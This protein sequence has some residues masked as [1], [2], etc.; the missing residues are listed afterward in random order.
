MYIYHYIQACVCNVCCSGKA[1]S[2]AYTECVFVTFGIQH[3]VHV[4]V[5]SVACLTLQYFSIS[6]K[7]HDFL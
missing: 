3:A 5:L 4:I 7:Q 6:H 2:I 1:K